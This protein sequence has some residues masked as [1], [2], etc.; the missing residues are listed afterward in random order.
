VVGHVSNSA[1]MPT[2]PQAQAE[3]NLLH[4]PGQVR[5]SELAAKSHDNA[6]DGFGLPPS[7]IEHRNGQR[8]LR[9]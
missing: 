3:E 4:S 6:L 1:V 8:T 7:A 9:R 5:D 2:Q